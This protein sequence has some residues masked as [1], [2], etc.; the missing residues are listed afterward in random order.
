M[1]K[2]TIV[3]Q[4]LSTVV[5]L[6]L[7]RLVWWVVRGVILLAVRFTFG[8]PLDG[9]MHTDAT[10]FSAGTEDIRER[11]WFARRN[12]SRW[13]FLPGY[14]RMAIRWG[15]VALVVAWFRW[16]TEVA[17]VGV[18]AAGV[19]LG[20]AAWRAVEWAT[21]RHHIARWVRPLHVALS[22]VV[23][24][25]ESTRPADWLDIPRDFAEDHAITTVTLPAT[26]TRGREIDK[27]IVGTVHDK[28][29]FAD[30]EVEHQWHMR[31]DAPYVEF[32]HA[33]RPPELVTFADVRE[34]IEAAPESAPLIGLGRG[35]K[36]IANDLDQENPHTLVSMGTGGGKSVLAAG[37]AAHVLHH[38]GQVVI[39]DL[40]RHSHPWARGLPGVTYVRDVIDIHNALIWLAAEGDQR[41][42]AADDDEAG[43]VDFTRTLVIFEEM[44]GTIGKLNKYWKKIKEKDDPALSPA[45]EGWGDMLFMGRAVK[46]NALGIG[47][48]MTARA[49]GGN[50]AREN[51]GNRILGRYTVNNW[52]MLVPEVWPMPRSSKRRG[53]VQVVSAGEADETQV[54]LW[55][56]DELRDWATSGT[57]SQ[58]HSLALTLPPAG[59]TP[60][61]VTAAG[62]EPAE[63]TVD[64]GAAGDP[65]ELVPAASVELVDELPAGV[66]D[67]RAGQP[68]EQPARELVTL[69]EAV[70]LGVVQLSPE[71][72]KALQNLRAARARDPEFP[73]SHGKRGVDLEYDPEELRVWERNRPRAGERETGGESA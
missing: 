57:P 31:G 45:V 68:V 9:N 47:Q 43:T 19:A 67:D 39:L 52:R 23:G 66:V 55:T 62:L 71:P 5:A 25:D 51:F 73:Q 16:R 24:V 44:N 60:V 65:V 15:L 27:A 37:Q 10:F 54:V 72:M 63:L 28:L 4:S 22:G 13:A 56:T 21:Y 49:A 26:H 50:E 29:G 14:K 8:L 17:V 7:S 1:S 42:R 46:M 64:A 48:L 36:P 69:R 18:L 30:S 59:N 35:G 61:T 58:G 2:T 20:L 33:P 32:R 38:G 3:K 70:E 40:K 6:V 12:P 41:N 34:L 53:R 11:K